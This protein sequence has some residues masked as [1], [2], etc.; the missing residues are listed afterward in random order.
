MSREDYAGYWKQVQT[1]VHKFKRGGVMKH[2]H[3]VVINGEEVDINSLTDEERRAI[4]DD[5]N[6]RA[7]A[8]IG[9]QEKRTA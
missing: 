5:L 9:Y 2:I 1:A 8:A 6:R 4:K 3:I 7:V